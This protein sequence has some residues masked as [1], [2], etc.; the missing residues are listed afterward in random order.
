MS[1]ID[2][3]SRRLKLPRKF[4]RVINFLLFM[5]LHNFVFF[6]RQLLSR[7]S[8]SCI[9]E[10]LN[11]DMSWIELML[12]VGCWIKN[13]LGGYRVLITVNGSQSLIW[14]VLLQYFKYRRSLAWS[15]MHFRSLHGSFSLLTLWRRILNGGK[16]F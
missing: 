3:I 2:T 14:L 11:R 15:C 6:E 4:M 16:Y 7:Y 10:R 12:L 1:S 9:N 13:A 8:W 5:V